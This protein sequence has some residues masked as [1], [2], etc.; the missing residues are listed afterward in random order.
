MKN[1]RVVAV[2][3]DHNTKETSGTIAEVLRDWVFHNEGILENWDLVKLVELDEKN[4][5][6]SDSLTFCDIAIQLG[7]VGLRNDFIK[8]SE[9]D[10]LDSTDQ[11]RF[12]KWFLDRYN[13]YEAGVL[14][15]IE[16]VGIVSI[17]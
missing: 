3:F 6:K 4:I 9:R 10:G 8:Q 12:D 17:T 11:E 16:R 13:L 2:D 7:F 5:L 1:L 14:R 15:Y